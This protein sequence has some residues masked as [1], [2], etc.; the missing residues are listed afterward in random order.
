M[1]LRAPL[2]LAFFSLVSFTLRAQPAT[3][4]R[5]DSLL[6]LMT[7]DEKVGQLVQYSGTSASHEALLRQ[8][9]IGSFLNIVG[10]NATGD[11]QRIAVEET[12]LK[13][14]LI[15]GLDVIHGYRTTFPI[16][17]A[18]SC[19]WDPAIIEQSERIAAV[20]A[21]AAG[22]NWT[23][24]PMVDIARDPRWGRIAERHLP[25]PA[26]ADFR[27]LTC[28]LQRLSLPASSILP[29]TVELREDGITILSTFPSVRCGT[30]TSLLTGRLSMPV[31]AV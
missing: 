17:L 19:S 29:H 3:E 1:S 9:R 28:T 23:F 27:D 18:T 21:T 4:R 7:L 26:S 22:V 24:A 6:T 13:I 10:A 30:S 14:P 5:V 12:R 15:F 20:E 31:R 11:I 16:P 2:I 25:P 8:G